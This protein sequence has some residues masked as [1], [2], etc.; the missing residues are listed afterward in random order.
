MGFFCE[1]KTFIGN[2]ISCMQKLTINTISMIYIDGV[3]VQN[4]TLPNE[5][6]QKTF[7]IEKTLKFELK[8]I[9]TSNSYFQNVTIDCIKTFIILCNLIN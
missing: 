9:E 8:L 3:F 1:S 7:F 6:I 4:L 5:I 2:I